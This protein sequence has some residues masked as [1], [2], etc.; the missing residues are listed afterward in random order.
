[1]FRAVALGGRVSEKGL[2]NDGAARIVKR[3]A[4]RAGLDPAQFAER[5]GSSPSNRGIARSTR[6]AAMFAG[7]ICSAS[8]RGRRFCDAS[9]CQAPLDRQ[10]RKMWF[11]ATWRIGFIFSDLLQGR[12]SL[13]KALW[14]FLVFGTFGLAI[15][16]AIIVL[17]LVLIGARPAAT[18]TYQ[19]I[20]GDIS[21][22]LL[23]VC[24]AVCDHRG[25]SKPGREGNCMG[26]DTG[27]SR[28]FKDARCRY[29]GAMLL[30]FNRHA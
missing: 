24:G 5:S 19:L 22:S 12:F 14:G 15:L 11:P 16:G 1:V 28:L 25:Q 17:P 7:S 20:F 26:G 8:M 29:R 6:C 4:E 3:Y 2:S 21:L 27:A 30:F 13:A 18:L 9:C 23:S 10:D